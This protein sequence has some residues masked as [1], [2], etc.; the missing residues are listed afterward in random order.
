MRR[1]ITTSAAFTLMELLAAV[2]LLVVLGTMLFTVFEQSSVV[3]RQASGRQTVFQQAKLLMEHLERELS[4]AY[5]NRLTRKTEMRPFMVKDNG[6]HIA[7]TTAAKV[8][9]TNPDSLN[10]GAEANLGRIGYYFN[11]A[12]HTIYRYEYYTLYGDDDDPAWVSEAT[13]FI[14]NVINF[15]IECYDNNSFQLM[16]WNSN[17]KKALPRAVRI[18]LRLTDDRHLKYYDGVDN[19]GNGTVD[20]YAETEDSIGLTCQQV[21]YLGD[22]N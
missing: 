2:T 8:R 15:N 16:N 11:E 9:D 10:Y 6:H 3:V 21:A 22:K 12:E 17:D 14:E 1:T 20:D 18:T 13:P 7:L 19:N 5:A 4:G